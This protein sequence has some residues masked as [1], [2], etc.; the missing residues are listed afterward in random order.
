MRIEI[1]DGETVIRTIEAEAEFAEAQHPGAWRLAAQQ[2][3][4]PAAVDDPRIWWMDVGPFYDRFGPD[5][6]A[7]AAS[8]HGACKAVQTLTGV[9]KYIDLKDPRIGT[10][11]DML[12]ATAQPE[13]QPWAP[14]SGP[15]N[16]EKK[17]VILTTPTTE[18]ERHVKGLIEAGG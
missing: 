2:N 17:A 1:M 4:P 11:I 6:I 3:M 12:I 15:M 8:D 7:I 5:A 14:G 18:Y 10:M 13:T 9:R 16:A